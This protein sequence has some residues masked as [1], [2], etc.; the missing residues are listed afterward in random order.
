MAKYEGSKLEPGR[1]VLDRYARGLAAANSPG[2]RLL[3]AITVM[4]MLSGLGTTG[5]VAISDMTWFDAFYMTVI[6]LTTVGYSEV[7]TL[8][9]A[10]RLFTIGL[11]TVGLGTALYTVG[12]MAEFIIEGRLLAVLGRRSMKKRLAKVR[13]HVVVCGFGRFGSAVVDALGSA[14]IDIVIIDDDP[15]MEPE[16]EKSGHQYVIGSGLDDKV[17]AEAG[18]ARARALVIATPS[19]ADNVFI[20]LAAREANAEITI[21]TRT[22]TEFGARRLR[23]AGASQIISPFALGGQRIAN[24]ILRPTVVDFIELSTPGGGAEFELE[25]LLLAPGCVLDGT[26]LRDLPRH[27]VKVSIVAIQRSGAALQII[28]NADAV[29]RAG[30]RVVVVGERSQMLKLSELAAA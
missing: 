2:R 22:A 5:Y 6:T 25:E 17:L 8:G 26:V 4:A 7:A 14:T 3:S 12:A 11:L 24:R 19:D 13:D 15:A 20:T 1:E 23:H 30:D 28:P 16:L 18:I 10:G 27:R 21:H 29:L 9:P